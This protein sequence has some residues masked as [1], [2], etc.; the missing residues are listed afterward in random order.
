MCNPIAP[1]L[2]EHLLTFLKHA[3]NP[4]KLM[5]FVIPIIAS[6]FFLDNYPLDTH[7]KLVC[8]PFYMNYL[9]TI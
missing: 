6:S 3:R 8:S 2:E 5:K 9:I 4:N 7:S 1:N